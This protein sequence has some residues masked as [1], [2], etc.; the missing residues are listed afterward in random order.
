MSPRKFFS[1]LRERAITALVILALFAVVPLGIPALRSEAISILTPG[2]TLAVDGNFEDATED[3]AAPVEPSGSGGKP[4]V[5]KRI[6]TS[7]ARLMA[8][9]FRGKDRNDQNAAASRPSAKDVGKFKTV[10]VSRTRDGMGSEVAREEMS[11]PNASATAAPSPAAPPAP[12]P[13]PNAASAERA[14]AAMFDQA[15]ELH[16]KGLHDGA[17]EKLGQALAVRPGFAEAHNLLGVCYD[18]KA[19]YGAAQNEYQQAIKIESGNPRFLNNLGYSYYLAGDDRN[20]IK[21]FQ[22]AL[23]TTPDDKRLHNNLGLAYGRRGEHKK[24]LEHFARSVGEAGAH[25][26]LGYVLNQQGRYE[27]AIREYEAALRLQP[28]SPTALSSLVPLYERTG[29]LREAAYASEMQKRLNS[30]ASSGA[31]QK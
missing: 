22:K 24:A 6:F 16:Q 11:A 4:G 17:I 14:A 10:P 5:F 19:M 20:A 13:Q 21:W 30:S 3:P 1:L 23:K 7:P 8:R 18:D 15:E 29:R 28:Q 9:L 25:L 31:Q 26:N 2:F 27:E 12:Q